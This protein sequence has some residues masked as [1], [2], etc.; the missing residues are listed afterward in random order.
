MSDAEGKTRETKGAPGGGSEPRI[1][2]EDD[3]GRRPF[4]R[5]I[6]VHS[7]MARGVSFEEAFRTANLVRDRTRH[8]EVVP[9]SFPGV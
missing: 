2:V 4:M 3:S 1:L 9:R 6:M 5:G 7:L 8:R